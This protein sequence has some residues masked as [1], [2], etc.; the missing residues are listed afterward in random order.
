MLFRDVIELAAVAV[1]NDGYQTETE[2]R[3]QVYADAKSI[4][5]NE[6]HAAQASGRKAEKRF[7]VQEGEYQ[8]EAHLYHDGRKYEIY[9]S[10][11]KGGFT[12]LYCSSART[13]A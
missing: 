12:E 9:R 5:M 4:G 8:G 13:G 3:R 1:S 11:S 10:F 7:D 2:T 6:Y